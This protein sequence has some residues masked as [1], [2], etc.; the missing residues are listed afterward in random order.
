MGA[1]C[2]RAGFCSKTIIPDSEEHPL[3]SSRAVPKAL[4]RWIRGKA[5]AAAAKEDAEATGKAVA[6]GAKEDEDAVGKTIAAAADADAD[7]TGQALAAAAEED[8]DAT[9]GA[10]AVAAEEDAESTGKAVTSAVK[11][12]AAAT[13]GAVTKAAKKNAAATTAALADTSDDA[14]ALAAIGEQIP[15][16]PFVPEDPPV[17]GPDP[18]GEGD[19]TT[20]GSPAPIE[21]I[22]GR[23]ADVVPGRKLNITDLLEL[24]SDVPAF[25]DNRLQFESFLKIDP[26]GFTSDE[27]QVGHTTMFV[28]KEWL[29]A[30]DIHEWSLEFTGYSEF[31]REWVPAP[32]KRI[33]EDEERVFFSVVVPGFSLWAISGS[34][35]APELVFKVQDLLV[36]PKEVNEGEPVL[37]QAVVENLSDDAAAYNAV[38]WLN[39]KAHAI[40]RVQVFARQKLPLSFRVQPDAGE[41]KVR[42]DRLLDSFTVKSLEGPTPTP[43]P[44][45]TP[46]EVPPPVTPTPT[47]VPPA[48]R[49]GGEIVGIVV[50]I[51]V[52]IAVAATIVAIYLR[53]GGPLEPPPP[54]EPPAGPEGPEGPSTAEGEE[55]AGAPPADPAPPPEEAAEKA[56]D[57]EGRQGQP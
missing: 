56:S 52:A 36:L 30:N 49:G 3:A 21:V 57:D 37:I 26:E 44:V 51:L 28:E 17:P 1:P 24:P 54:T 43:T 7:S 41:Y 25:P 34:D 53:G 42:F 45:P 12:N 23:F 32:A 19:W 10:I 29:K 48:V 46:T 39:S 15:V 8:D 31:R 5:V 2:F 11:T 33:R 35:K 20:L 6:A 22:L 14:E 50:G 4:L 13:S 38:L 9:G 47:V 27:L 40:E 55:Q 18:S 16:E